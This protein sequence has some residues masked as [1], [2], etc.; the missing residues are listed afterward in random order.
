MRLR[1]FQ[2]LKA[3]MRNMLM[4]AAVGIGLAAGGCLAK[5]G[6]VYSA[7]MPSD[8]AMV[9]SD[10]NRDVGDSDVSGSGPE[11]AS[12]DTREAP[13]ASDVPLTGQDGATPDDQAV[14]DQSAAMD[15][16]D[17]GLSDAAA[18]VFAPMDGIADLRYP[19]TGGVKYMGPTPHDAATGEAGGEAGPIIAKYVAPMPDAANDLGLTVRYMAQIPDAGA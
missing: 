17:S 2:F 12:L 19:E 18:D 7:S 10:V 14:A 4:P 8:A 13:T 11:V 9:K 16:V 3:R 1:V 5:S 6:A 15:A